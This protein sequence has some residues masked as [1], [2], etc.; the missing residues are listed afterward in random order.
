MEA[1]DFSKSRYL[2]TELQDFTTKNTIIFQVLVY[3]F[4]FLT[5]KKL[6]KQFTYCKL[7]TIIYKSEW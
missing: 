3:P 4:K 7:L 1:A 5:V 2:S 6:G